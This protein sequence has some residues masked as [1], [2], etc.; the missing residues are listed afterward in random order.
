MELQPP[1]C[2]QD[3]IGDR[4]RG[5]LAGVGVDAAQRRVLVGVAGA[6][7]GHELL[8]LGAVEAVDFQEERVHNLLSLLHGKLAF[9]EVLL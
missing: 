6:G 2:L 7:D 1:D 9:L 3:H 8:R 4:V 5:V